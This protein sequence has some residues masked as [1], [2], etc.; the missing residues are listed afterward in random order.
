MNK[1]IQIKRFVENN[2]NLQILSKSIDDVNLEQLEEEGYA[3]L[4]T[5][6]SSQLGQF[7]YGAILEAF[8]ENESDNFEDDIDTIDSYSKELA[9]YLSNLTGSKLSVGFY[10]AD[11][12][13]VVFLE[14]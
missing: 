12:S 2:I 14:Q 1:E 13:Y 11:G 8:G 5:I 9:D 6:F 10:E 7:I 4:Y 3:Y